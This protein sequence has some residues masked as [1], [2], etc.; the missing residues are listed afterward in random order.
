MRKN[1]IDKSTIK[2]IL[3]I[4]YR[5]VGDALLSTP[6]VRWLRGEFPRAS[7]TYLIDADLSPLLE[8]NP[9]IDEIRLH[10]RSN[11]SLL[12]DIRA[13]ARIRADRYDLIVDLQGGPRGALTSLLS[14]AR[15]RLGHPTFARG[16]IA[17]NIHAPSIPEENFAWM[18]Q[19]SVLTPLGATIPRSP[20]F[21]LSSSP[22]ARQKIA[23]RLES[24]RPDANAP[25]LAIHPG[26][27]KFPLKLYPREKIARLIDWIASTFD[28]CPILIGGG[29]DMEEIDRIG[30][31]NP[32]T[33]VL[34]D[35]AL[36]EMIA[37]IE[38]TEFF[39]GIDSGVMHIAEAFGK[40]IVALFGPSSVERWAPTNINSRVVRCEPLECMPCPH[41]SCHRPDDS[42]MMRLQLDQVKEAVKLMIDRAGQSSE[43]IGKS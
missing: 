34:G 37:L 3:I 36:D 30:P 39:V 18:M 21:R 15:Y 4:R 13:I 5:S 8:T 32:K 42:C 2:K 6:L 31:L 19:F 14:G 38:R 29:R 25:M 26:G 12:K 33:R 1:A 35:L 28:V 9:D 41:R 27:P 10:Q 24:I 40:N 17:Y 20:E 7:I 11:G 43:P 23:R 22:I 16:R